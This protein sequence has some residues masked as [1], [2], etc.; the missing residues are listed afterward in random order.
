[1]IKKLLFF[2]LCA[3]ISVS[4]I[5]CQ[6]EIPF[7]PSEKKV[8]KQAIAD[9]TIIAFEKSLLKNQIDSVFKKYQFN[10]SVA[11]FKDSVELYRKNQGFA[12]FKDQ[13]KMIFL[14]L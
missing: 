8:D 9:S 7:I 5:S 10:G 13:L 12:D 6:K 4:L 14:T 2:A 1:M 3:F 11:V